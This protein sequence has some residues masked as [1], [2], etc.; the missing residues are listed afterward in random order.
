MWIYGLSEK[1]SIRT[2]SIIVCHN[3]T[4]Y[5]VMIT[6]QTKEQTGNGN[7]EC[8]RNTSRHL[9]KTFPRKIL[10]TRLSWVSEASGRVYVDTG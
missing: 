10:L 4:T 1:T 9:P 7:K 3:K 5:K 6:G 2:S 8:T